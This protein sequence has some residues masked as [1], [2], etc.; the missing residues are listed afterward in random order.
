MFAT[1][2]RGGRKGD[3]P[4]LLVDIGQLMAASEQLLAQ[5]AGSLETA[6]GAAGI[7]SEQL[8]AQPSSPETA[9]GAAGILSEQLEAQLEAQPSSPDTAPGAAEQQLPSVPQHSPLVAPGAAS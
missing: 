7:L 5:P 6:P 2:A 9:P 4:L 3:Q 1:T 8:E